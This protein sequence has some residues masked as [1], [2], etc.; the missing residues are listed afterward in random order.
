MDI[1][2]HIVMTAGRS[3]AL[4]LYVNYVNKCKLVLPERHLPYSVASAVANINGVLSIWTHVTSLAVRDTITVKHAISTACNF[5]YNS[6]SVYWN[7]LCDGQLFMFPMVV[8]KFAWCAIT[9][10]SLQQSV[11]A[12]LQ[13]R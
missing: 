10:Q 8:S 2:C 7:Q 6:R 11:C 1:V 9:A 13:G 4:C 12:S 3:P 5:F